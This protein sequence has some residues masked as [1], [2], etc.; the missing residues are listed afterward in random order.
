[1]TAFEYAPAPETTMPQIAQQ[2]ELF[3]GGKWSSPRSGRYFETV[4]PADE[5]PLAHVAHAGAD[6]VDRAVQ[7]LGGRPV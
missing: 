3:V 7:A 6:D 2:Y 4:N 5:T 1:M